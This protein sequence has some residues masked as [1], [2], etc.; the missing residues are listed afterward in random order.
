MQWWEENVTF[1]QTHLLL[2]E[3]ISS[4]N[5][6]EHPSK[7]TLVYHFMASVSGFF[8]APITVKAFL[9]VYVDVGSLHHM[10]AFLC[11]TLLP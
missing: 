8:Q 11:V 2:K 3:W 5:P 6:E 1:Y 10:L 4:G 7:S 9:T